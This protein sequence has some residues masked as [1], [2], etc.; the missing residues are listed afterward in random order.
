[1]VWRR[2]LTERFDPGMNL[3]LRKILNFNFPL[4]SLKSF[5]KKG[6]QYGSNQAGIIRTNINQPRYIRITDIDEFG[7]L[8]DNLGAT[9]LEIEKKYLLENNDLLFARSGA[10]VGK[11]YLH[12]SNHVN[13]A[14]FFAGYMIRFVFDKHKINPDYVYYYTQLNSYRDWV[15]SIQRAAGQ[16][17]I[18]AEEYKSLLIP[19]PPFKIQTQIVNIFQNAYDKKRK[20]E[21]EAKTLIEG[22]DDYLLKEL[23]I[24]LPERDTSLE[25]RIFMADFSDM[26]G[27]RFD[28]D[29]I[30]KID[31]ISNSKA[32]Y[33]KIKLK[34]LL[35]CSPQYGA[36][37]GAI[38]PINDDDTRYIRITDI[39]NYGNLKHESWKTTQE[40][41]EQYL[42]NYN[43]I[44][45]ARSGSV[46]RCYIHKEI[47]RK[48]IFAGYLIRFVINK[49]ICNPD[50]LFYYCHSSFYKF[51]VSA[52]ERP[53]VQSNIN[54]EEYKSLPVIL[55]P[56][57][58]QNEIA[59]KIQ[60]I[61]TRA[62]Q[63]QKEAAEEM[64]AA[65]LEVERMILGE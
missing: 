21:A 23:G 39:D 59:E 32:N 2:A 17:N 42:L 4:K 55:P 31:F 26:S 3:Y 22:I 27:G 46:G 15:Q 12:K 63:L 11:A 40:I 41:S 52:I 19:T 6:P 57:E 51:W 48:A 13:Y 49:K 29:Y 37:E 47:K 38:N 33:S 34:N 7:V 64:E 58:K 53:A 44:L 20:K 54:S 61:R 10:T 35:L 24:S 5:L 25:S 1:M 60:D 18:N 9:A 36:N 8:K 28:P 43:D 45:F 50:Y 62:K 65:K 16:P 56:I 14:C 30:S